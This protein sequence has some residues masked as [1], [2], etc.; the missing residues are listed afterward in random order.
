MN[1]FLTIATLAAALTSTAA[2]AQSSAPSSTD[3]PVA[4]KPHH[5]PNPHKQAMHLSKR[6]GLTSDQTAKLEPI[7]ADRDQKMLALR[8]D[9]SLTDAQRRQQ[10]HAV[11]EG[12]RTQLSTVLTP[13]QMQQVKAMHH[14]HET[15]SAP[16]AGV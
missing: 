6:L 2:F 13:D 12:T 14:R 5:A 7:L 1:R 15:N 10:M 9:T 11:Q 8:S 3:A 4:A 16:P